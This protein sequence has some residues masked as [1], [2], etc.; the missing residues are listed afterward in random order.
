MVAMKN[1]AAWTEDGCSVEISQKSREVRRNWQQT[2][3]SLGP[4]K[5]RLKGNYRTE[6]ETSCVS[7]EDQEAHCRM[8]NALIPH[9]EE[10]IELEHFTPENWPSSDGTELQ[11]I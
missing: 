10:M 11:N 2:V 4:R 1:G 3:S 7:D 9:V 5:G 8:K 6:R